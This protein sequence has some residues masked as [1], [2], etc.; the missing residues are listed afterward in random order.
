VNVLVTGASGFIGGRLCRALI[1]AG[2]QVRAF[3][4][5]TSSLKNL[6]GLEVV[7]AL[8]DIT[9]PASLAEAMRGIEVVFH[10]AAQVGGSQDPGQ[11]YTIT[12]EGTRL[13][14]QA[15]LEGGVRRVVHT[16]SAAALGVPEHVSSRNSPIGLMDEKHT[17]NY[18]PARWHSGYAKYLAELEVQKAVAAG[19]DVVIVNPTGVFGPGDVYRVSNS[20]LLQAANGHLPFSTAGGWN[21][22]HLDD[23]ITGH[24][25]ALESGRRGERYILGGHNMTFTYFL[26]LVDQASGTHPSRVNLP[27]GLVRALS[28]PVYLARPFTKQ[29]ID[30]ELLR[31]AGRFFYYDTGKAIRELGLPEPRPA[32]QAIQ[33]ALAWFRQPGG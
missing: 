22:V 3:H 10:T 13:V 4:R 16:S 30:H 15:A 14:L 2:H 9:Q 12:V 23:V 20:I 21:V 33:D 6:E 19:L 32:L 5:P 31:L 7:H 28:G 26:G 25:A 11:V 17:W 8:G 18:H 24:L 1:A 29:P 27:A